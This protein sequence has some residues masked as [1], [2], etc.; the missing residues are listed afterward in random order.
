MNSGGGVVT[1]VRR[2]DEPFKP[3][4]R[5]PGGVLSTFRVTSV[6]EDLWQTEG[7]QNKT[8]RHS[9]LGAASTFLKMVPGIIE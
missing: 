6:V 2:V 8:E 9:I 7:S 1:N 5:Y 3:W 4:I